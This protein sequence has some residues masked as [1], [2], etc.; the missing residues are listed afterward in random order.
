MIKVLC[1]AGLILGFSMAA[2]AESQIKF[3]SFF[4]T[5]TFYAAEEKEGDFAFLVAPSLRYV[6]TNSKRYTFSTASSASYTKYMSN[7]NQDFF[8]YDI[9]LRNALRF[10]RYFEMHITP[11]VKLL[12]EPALGKTEKR[13]DRQYMGAGLGFK[14]N[15]D[16]RRQYIFEAL[17]L[18]ESM[19]QSQYDFLNNHT[20]EAS[21]YYKKY[22]LPE[23]FVYLGA[24]GDTRIFPDGTKITTPVNRY[25]KYDSQRIEPGVGLEGRLTRY[26]KIRSYLGYAFI[27]YEKDINYRDPVYI[28]ELEEEISPKDFLLLGLSNL[29]ADSYFTNYQSDQKVYVG[30]GRFIG[31][32][33]LWV[34]KAEYLYR[35]YSRPRRRD[36]QRFIFDTRVEIS[37]SN[38][39]KIEGT[40][41]FDA[42]TSDAVNP[43]TTP[44]DPI[45]SYQNIKLGIF[46]KYLF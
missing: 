42:L 25:I 15:K 28:L 9:S 11:A 6:S 10:S 23:T 2:K 44:I 19:S 14:I 33:V 38:E 46:G 34:S 13:L 26:F 45:A 17:Y 20:F 22:F 7:T 3:G 5:N 32:R 4:E 31:D 35:T 39:L 8:D 41:M 27:Q 1:L 37:C 36:D 18:Q 24:K 40:L 16:S 30:Y 12:S 29:A 43:D 21:L